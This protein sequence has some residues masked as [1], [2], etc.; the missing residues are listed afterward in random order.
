MTVVTKIARIV[1]PVDG[2][3]YATRDYSSTT[4]IDDAV[5]NASDA[6]K[7][8]KKTSIE[9]RVSIVE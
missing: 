9:E 8:W 4:E 2:S 3:V 1:S 6:F 7:E 5:D